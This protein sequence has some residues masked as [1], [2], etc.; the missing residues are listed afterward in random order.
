MESASPNGSGGLIAPSAGMILGVRAGLKPA[1]TYITWGMRTMVKPRLPIRRFDVFAEYNRRKAL[2]DGI[3]EDDAEGYGLW[4][5]KVVASRRFGS[6][7]FSQAPSKVRES[8]P[9]EPGE[10]E[11]AERSKWHS[12]G[13]EPQT[14]ELFEKEIVNRMGREFYDTVFAPAIAQAVAEDRSYNA[15]RDAIRKDWRP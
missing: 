3:P 2:A 9:R 11:Q 5:A 7:V 8:A 12:L 1:P 14:D 4:V 13:G 10:A 15:I 6:G